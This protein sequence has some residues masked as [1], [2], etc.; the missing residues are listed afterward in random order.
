MAR[1]FSLARRLRLVTGFTLAALGVILALSPLTVAALLSRPHE[2]GP[3]MINLR[4]SF[5]GSLFGLGLFVVWLDAL[6]PWR[7]LWLGLLAFSM[8]G[9]GLAR[10]LGFALD[11]HPDTLQW[12][13][14][15]LEIA[16]VLGASVALHRSSRE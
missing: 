10:I 8:A 9:I 7:R 3:Q 15:G 11:G 1:P 6:R 14:L 16:L 4:A 5:G 2:T 12:I 13:W